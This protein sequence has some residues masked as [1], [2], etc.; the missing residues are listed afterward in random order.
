[1]TFRS[2]PLDKEYDYIIVGA[3]AAGCVLANRLS[4]DPN[5]TVLLIEAGG[6]DD[7]PNIYKPRALNKL[8]TD[9]YIDWMY[10]SVPQNKSCLALK[11]HRSIWPSGKVLGGSTALN[12]MMFVR[13]NREDFDIWEEMG[14]KGWSYKDVL[15]Y[16]IKLETYNGVDGDPGYR[17]YDGPLNVEKI[18]FL[19]P[20]ARA[21]VAAAKEMGLNEIDY[22]GESQLGVSFT[23]S[24]IHKGQRFT[25]AKAY[26]HPVRYRKN[27]FVLTDTSVRS[28]KLDGDKAVGVSV[29][30]TKEYRTGTE[31]LI[32]AKKEVILSAG[33]VGSTKILLLSGIGPREHLTSVKI[34]VKKDLPV[35]KNLQDHIQMPFPILLEDVPLDSGVSLTE[36]YVESLSSVLQYNLLGIGPLS[37]SG[38]EAHAFFRSGFEEEGTTAPDIQLILLSSWFTPDLLRTYSI[39]TKGAKTLWGHHVIE[40]IP[41]SGYILFST[42]LRP[43][44]IGEIGLDASDPLNKPRINPNYYGNPIDVEVIVRGIRYAQKLLNTTAF[45]PYRGRVPSKDATSPYEYNSDDFWRWYVRHPTL[46]IFH[47]VGTCKMGDPNDPSTVVDPQLKVKGFKNL[48][49]VDASVMPKVVAANTNAATVMIAEKAADLIK[50]SNLH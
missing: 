36:P 23:Q 27:L 17:G 9:P 33:S 21:F 3:G 19:T 48:R 12:G 16:F 14:A 49:V 43:R 1:M 34:P 42:L 47:P 37:S 8:W 41:K 32:K 46:T 2:V 7:N 4:E 25:A 30:D 29:V 6:R 45:K 28:L 10:S 13:G 50:I 38:A 39:S 5:V 15:P 22:N 40:D 18:P 11:S 26:L 20:L 31:T 44:S 35:G 24:T